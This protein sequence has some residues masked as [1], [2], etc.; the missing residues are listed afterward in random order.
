LFDRISEAL[1]EQFSTFVATS[2]FES[3]D[4]A[5]EIA[6]V[7]VAQARLASDGGGA[8][9]IFGARVGWRSH[10][11]IVVK[12]GD[13]PR[14]F[15]RDAGKKLGQLPQFVVAVVKAG[16]EQGDD[17][18]PDAHFVKTSNSIEDRLETS[19]ELAIV[20]IVEALEIDFI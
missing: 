14:D 7:D 10:F 16:N 5:A 2:I 20:M 9:H 17:L 8:L 15:R 11:V 12:G 13:V 1:D 3:G 18:E 19:A 6:G 4:T